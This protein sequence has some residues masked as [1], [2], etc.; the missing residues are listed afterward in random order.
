MKV[1]LI[2]AGCGLAILIFVFALFNTIVANLVISLIAMLAVFELLKATNCFQNKCCGLCAVIFA[3]VI[4]FLSVGIVARNLFLICYSYAL[5]LFLTLL[6]YHNTFHIEQVA[7]SF[8]F[9]LTIPFSLSTILYIR[10][11][12]GMAMGIF[13]ALVIVGS[14]W[15]SDSGAYFFGRAFGKHK[16]APII[17]PKK[18]VEGAIGGAFTAMVCLPIVLWLVTVISA[19]FG[20]TMQIHYF[21][22]ELFIP[23]F[24]GV[25]IL[26][27]L[28]ASVIK[29]QFGVKDY[30]SIMPGHGGIMD[31]FDSVLLVAPLVL[32]ISQHCPLV[33]LL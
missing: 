26:G 33:S 25:S 2:S 32:V 1:R 12:F 8:L 22:L 29:R 3:G 23:V 31:R 15:L 11:R 24:S 13:Y 17:S 10:D 14:A 9:S 20:V 6:R 30:G 7:L 4:P 21:T 27:D 19:A 16:L 18:S 5:L 28:S